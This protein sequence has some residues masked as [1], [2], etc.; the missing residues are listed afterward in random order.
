M[1]PKF[2]IHISLL[3]ILVQ[4]TLT[5]KCNFPKTLLEGYDAS[6]T[7]FL[8]K[9]LTK[10]LSDD[11]TQYSVMFKTLKSWKGKDDEFLVVKTNSS[12]EACGVNFEIGIKYFI[13]ATEKDGNLSATVCS[14]TQPMNVPMY[15]SLAKMRR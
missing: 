3:L 6:D 11:K 5:C 7:V 8:G 9:A 2:L 14:L 15:S 4:T 12:D 10:D 13:F 1:T